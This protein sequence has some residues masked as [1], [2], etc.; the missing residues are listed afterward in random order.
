MKARVAKGRNGV[1]LKR[2]ACRLIA[3]DREE[4]EKF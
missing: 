1:E 3:K 2:N 4:E